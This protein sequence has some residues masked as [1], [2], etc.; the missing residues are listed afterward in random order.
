MTRSEESEQG[1][2]QAFINGLR[3]LTAGSLLSGIL[4]VWQ[5]EF[6]GFGRIITATSVFV[7]MFGNVAVMQYVKPHPPSWANTVLTVFWIGLI[8]IGVLWVV[9]LGMGE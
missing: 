3:L 4:S 7:A 6:Q 2:S 8:V 5:Y 1:V 9:A